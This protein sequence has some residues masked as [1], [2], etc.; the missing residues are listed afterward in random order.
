MAWV[1]VLVFELDVGDIALAFGVNGV[2]VLV[3]ASLAF[4]ILFMA[5]NC[6]ELFGAVLSSIAMDSPFFIVWIFASLNLASIF[7]WV[8]KWVWVW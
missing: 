5:F 2:G 6:A 8:W 7:V 4:N 3:L 1:I